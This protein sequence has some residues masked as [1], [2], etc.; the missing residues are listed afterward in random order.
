[1]FVLILNEDG[2]IL[3]ITGTTSRHHHVVRRL[4]HATGGARF[5][6]VVETPRIR[7]L[8]LRVLGSRDNTFRITRTRCR[9]N[10]LGTIPL[11]LDELLPQ[12]STILRIPDLHRCRDFAPS[13]R[14]FCARSVRAPSADHYNRTTRERG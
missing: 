9:D 6:T 10:N 2:V 8:D 4:H 12:V 14:A 7:G 5:A 11:A 13:V 3:T 1:M